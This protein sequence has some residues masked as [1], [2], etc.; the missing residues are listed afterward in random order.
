MSVKT[1]SYEYENITATPTAGWLMSFWFEGPVL[2]YRVC[3]PAHELPTSSDPLRSAKA[4][5]PNRQRRMA[6]AEWM[7]LCSTRTRLRPDSAKGRRAV[8]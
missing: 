5:A 3:V 4:R 2:Y 7:L 6:G 1:F 8:Q